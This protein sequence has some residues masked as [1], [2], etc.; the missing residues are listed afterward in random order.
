LPTAN[1]WV[2]P[3]LLLAAALFA[4]QMMGGIAAGEPGTGDAPQVKAM[5]WPMPGRSPA[6]DPASVDEVLA[7]YDSAYA[8]LATPGQLGQLRA[9]HFL[10]DALPPEPARPAAAK[11]HSVT[12]ADGGTAAYYVVQFVAPPTPGWLQRVEDLGAWRPAAAALSGQS[13]ILRLDSGAPDQVRALPFVESVTA[14]PQEGRLAPEVAVLPRDERLDVAV[15][16]FD[17][18]D[19]LQVAARIEAAGGRLLSRDSPEDSI[20]LL[21]NMTAGAAKELAARPEVRIVERYLEPAPVNDVA[22]GLTGVSAVRSALGLTGTGQ[23][24]AVADTGLDTGSLATMHPDFAGRIVAHFGYGRA[25]D[26]SP[27]IGADP[28]QDYPWN[29]PNG[30]GTHVAGSVLGDGTQSAGAITGM[31]PDA[32]L[33]MQSLYAASWSTVGGAAVGP[34]QMLNDAYSQG[35]RIQTNSWG[36]DCGTSCPYTARAASY[37]DYLFDH[38]DLLVL[39]AAGNSGADA[40]GNGVIDASSLGDPATAKNVLTVGASES[41]RP[42][43]ASC[44]WFACF[45]YASSPLGPDGAADDANGL[46]AFSSRGPTVDGRI[47]PDL[48]A[49]G[50]FILSTRSGLAPSGNFWSLYTNSEYAYMGGTSMATPLVAGAAAVVRE[51]LV[52]EGFTN[53]SGALVKAVLIN[54]ANDLAPGQ[55]GTGSTQELGAAPDYNQGWGRLDIDSFLTPAGPLSSLV[56][57][58]KVGLATG[59]FVDLPFAVAD[60]SVPVQ[61]TLAWTDAAGAPGCNPCLVNNLDVVVVGPTG[62]TYRGNQFL[63]PIGSKV[64]DQASVANPTSRDLRNNVERIQLPAGAPVGVYQLRVNA[65]SVPSGPQPFAVVVSAGLGD[66]TDLAVQTTRSVT[67]PPIGEEFDLVVTVTNTGDADAPSVTVTD[68]LAAGLVLEDVVVPQENSTCS[69]SASVGGATTVSCGLGAIA[70]GDSAAMTLKVHG[71]KAGALLN[72]A[73]ASA[74]GVGDG[75]PANDVSLLTTVVQ[76]PSADLAVTN[77]DSA[78]PLLVGRPLTYTVTVTNNGPHD[79]PGVTLTDTLPPAMAYGTPSPSQGTCNRVS[80]VVTCLL[81][82]LPDGE[83]ATVTFPMTPTSA[84]TATN[85]AAASVTGGGVDPALGNNRVAQPTTIRNPQANLAV[86][87]TDSPDPL[88]AGSQLT[89]TVTVTNN[90]PDDAP[91]VTL[92][93]TLP[94]GMS[95]GAIATSQGSCARLAAT[96]TCVLGGLANGQAATLTFAMT[97]T[98]AATAATNTASATVTGGGVDP[99]LTD[100]RVVQSTRVNAPSTNLAVTDVD[101]VDPILTGRLLTH[102]VTVTNNGPH[103]APGVTLAD[104]LPPGMAYG[105]IVPSQ[106]SCSRVATAVTCLLGPM[107]NGATATVTLPMTPTTPA[108]AATNT[109]VVS[110]TGGAVDPVLSDNRVTQATRVNAPSANLVVTNVDD[111]DPLLTGRLLTYTVTVTNNGPDDAPGVTLTDTL[112]SGMAYGAITTSQ[113][114]CNRV[115]TT[116]TCP[117]GALPNGETATLTFAMTPTVAALAATNTASAAVT[118]GGMDPVLTNNRVAQATRVNA[119]STDLAVTNVDSLD[120]LLA[121]QPLTY[122]VTVTNNGPDD[123]PGVT[124]TDTLPAGMAYGTPVSSQGSCGRVASV[125]TCLLGPLADGEVATVTLPMT[126]TFAATAATNTASATATGGAVDPA[127]AN[128]RVVQATRVNAPSANLAVTNQDDVDPILAG[129]PLTYTVTVT[130][131][132][133]DDAPGVTLTDTLPSGMAY[134]ALSTSQGSCSRVGTAVTCLL[135]G[136]ANGATATLTLPM[137]PTLAATAATNTASATVTGGGVDP[138]LTNNRVA[139]ATRVNAPSA[140]LAVTALDDVDPLFAGQLLTSTVTVTNNG[141]DGAPGVTL[142]NTLPGGMAYGAITPSQ[143]SCTR[144]STSATCL[145]GPLASGGTATVTFPMTPTVAATAATHGASVTVTG[146]GIDPIL[147]DNRASQATR[148]NAPSSNLAMAIVDTADPAALGTPFTY[149]ATVTNNGPD[150]APG[151]TVVA[152]LPTGATY[153]L[154]S[155]TQGSCTRAATTVTCQLGPLANAAS[156]TVTMTVTPTSAGARSS[157]A[158][159]SVT[160]GGLDPSLADNR[161]TQATTFQ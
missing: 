92:V 42:T 66:L 55:Y 68:V 62:I 143:G 40:N 84:G 25:M 160:G 150:G 39:F 46:A 137:T 97:P 130:N 19:A 134:G 79:A 152:N 154:V 13:L 21:A 41:V 76:T 56:H 11:P 135:G 120:P 59:G 155:A 113:G 87:N 90:G 29:D 44:T 125:V 14:V 116:V 98:V 122:T 108:L 74:T 140:N 2:R 47:K 70:A 118:G 65:A 26:G 51:G 12:L 141:P 20:L 93:D 88:L 101:D 89:Y 110:A 3:V 117:L 57:D 91:G 149:E 138:V 75:N 52:L 48:V 31:A 60:N 78:D 50:T 45:D 72:R 80:T 67:S 36:G 151:V 61:A 127:L 32:S 132:G 126:P 104:T 23:T 156:A 58:Q 128:N 105:T 136:L 28:G 107:A 147:S 94:A 9:Q 115:G 15:M 144:V 63:Q 142:F 73:T 10:V 24:I 139:Q 161:A 35:A 37:D 22:A 106:G 158:S 83:S 16:L 49:P 7:E 4:L 96:V 54:S 114:T 27:D 6:F 5:V 43:F 85:T 123:A 71:T 102:T 77:T 17:G 69:G 159:A 1:A 133:P 30:H 146:G 99:V 145:L 38:P 34:T 81:G 53:P 153:G 8:V 64:G 119:P 129:Q 157:T 18:A 86:T 111:V 121:G 131:N 82:R 103:D 124:L 95:Y 33:V 112:P 148:V 109:A 100:N